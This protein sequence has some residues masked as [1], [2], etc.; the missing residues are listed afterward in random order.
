MFPKILEKLQ[1]HTHS[2]SN[3]NTTF[4]QSCLVFNSNV[5]KMLALKMIYTSFME[6]FGN[7]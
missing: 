4:I 3:V 7:T 2:S 5:L 6:C 1:T